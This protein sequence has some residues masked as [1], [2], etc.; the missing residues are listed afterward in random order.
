MSA[1]SHLLVVG[2]LLTLAFGLMS[3]GI[4]AQRR[5]HREIMRRWAPHGPDFLR[6]QAE[7]QST[8]ADPSFLLRLLRNTFMSAVNG[9]DSAQSISARLAV[10][11]INDM[12][13]NERDRSLLRSGILDRVGEAM[14]D[15]RAAVLHGRPKGI[16]QKTAELVRAL[17]GTEPAGRGSTPDIEFLAD[18]GAC[19][20][21]LRRGDVGLARDIVNKWDRQR[22][23]GLSGEP[24]LAAV[25][26]KN[27]TEKFHDHPVTL[28]DDEAAEFAG[29]LRS[30]IA[31]VSGHLRSTAD[32]DTGVIWEMLVKE[33]P[34][35]TLEGRDT[36]SERPEHQ[37]NH[38][39]P[40]DLRLAATSR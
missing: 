40:A 39:N 1:M 37:V 22:L 6:V 8:A 38:P 32:A 17:L 15:Y 20:T 31:H 12:Q 18:L 10:A 21:A 2:I 11:A 34:A 4:V 16:A 14:P 29:T 3:F 27:I 26:I 35:L 28:A 36:M 13:A 33:W 7:L 23:A 5:S 24:L 9:T 19:E 25:A 30:L